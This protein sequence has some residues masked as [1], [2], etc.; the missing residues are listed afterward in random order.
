MATV[1]AVSAFLILIAKNVFRAALLLLA[2]LISM[3]GIYIYL[4]AEFMAMV[5][6]L[7]YAGGVVVLIIFAIMLTTRI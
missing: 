7:I 5:Q 4:S 2:C 6:I 1:T 3:A